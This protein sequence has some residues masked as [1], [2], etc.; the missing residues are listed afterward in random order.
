MTTGCRRRQRDAC[1]AQR[2]FRSRRTTSS[3]PRSSASFSRRRRSLSLGPPRTVTRSTTRRMRASKCARAASRWDRGFIAAT[4]DYPS[5]TVASSGVT[6]GGPPSIPGLAAA[7]LKCRY[8]QQ[9]R[10][11]ADLRVAGRRHSFPPRDGGFDTPASGEDDD[12]TPCFRRRKPG[13]GERPSVLGTG[14]VTGSRQGIHAAPARPAGQRAR[15]GH[16]D[17][18][19]TRGDGPRSCPRR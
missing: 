16:G 8:P 10:R 3:H 7:M 9:S 18:R 1:V 13:G 6:G 14:A 2:C 12:P 17:T 15:G 5:A 19:G 11:T 4:P